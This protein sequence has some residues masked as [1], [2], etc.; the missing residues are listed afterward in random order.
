VVK[1]VNTSAALLR[2]QLTHA[3][4]SSRW[5]VD[6]LTDDAYFWEPGPRC[7][8]VRPR[9]AAVSPAPCGRRDW[10]I[11]GE[12]PLTTDPPLATIAWRIVH[13][14]AWT[15]IYRDWTFG[16][17]TQ[18]YDTI[19]IPSDAAASVRWLHRAQ[20]SF[21]TAVGAADDL[22][23]EKTWAVHWGE[24]FAIGALVWQIA[25]EHVHHGAE[26]GVLRD[27]HRGHGR[28]AMWPEPLTM[29]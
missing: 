3:F 11:D 27:L 2:Q 28:Q 8:S 24:N 26:I 12:W 15:E 21:M 9:A 7:W 17:A 13:L 1:S 10:V 5:H 29:S 14:A 6:G 22:D 16:S 25:V 4:E 20:D 19:D 23:F 18:S